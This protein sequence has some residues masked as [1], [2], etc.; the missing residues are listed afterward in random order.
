METIE[1]PCNLC[2]ST[3]YEVVYLERNGNGLGTSRLPRAHAFACTSLDHG[4]FGRIVRCSSCQLLFRSP[5][6][7]LEDVLQAYHDVVDETYVEEQ[8]GRRR[9]FARS[10]ERLERFVPTRGRLLDVGCS[11]GLFL[12]VARTRRWEVAGMEPSAWATQYATTRLGLPV[13]CGTLHETSF[14]NESFHVVTMW[15]VLE[16]CMDPS[17]ELEAVHRLLRPGG[18]CCIGTMNIDSWFARCLGRRWPWLMQMH[19]YYWTPTTLERLLRKTGFEL[20]QIEPYP[21]IFSLRYLA[22]KLQAYTPRLS[23]MASRAIQRLRL[24]DVCVAFDCGDS[25]TVYA[26]KVTGEV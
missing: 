6:E 16:H 26:R 2:G 5:R 1:V 7:P 10:L 15:D 25:I 22:W 17:Q 14:P 19:L 20:I 11:I 18:V 4:H 9:T 21:H 12:E 13:V 3:E 23:V 8:A 24:G